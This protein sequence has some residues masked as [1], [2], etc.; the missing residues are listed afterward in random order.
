[1]IDIDSYEATIFPAER[2]ENIK[3]L[4][5]KIQLHNDSKQRKSR[6]DIESTPNVGNGNSAYR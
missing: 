2:I 3:Q 5:A 4:P 6:R 1:M